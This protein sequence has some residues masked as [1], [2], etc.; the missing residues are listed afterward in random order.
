MCDA[1]DADKTKKWN[2]KPDETGSDVPRLGPD[3]GKTDKDKKQISN[4]NGR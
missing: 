2:H 1:Y 3:L 4:I